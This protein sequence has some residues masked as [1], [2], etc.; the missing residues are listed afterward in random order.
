MLRRPG[1]PGRAALAA[2]GVAALGLSCTPAL[3]LWR[4]ARADRGRLASPPPGYVDDASRLNRTAVREVW[5]VPPDSAAAEAALAA[6]VRRAAREG[7]P[8]SIAGARHSQGGHTFAPG[9]LVVDLRAFR[10]MRL[11]PDG[12]VL[13]VQAGA[14]WSEVL[15]FLHARGRSVA[16]MQSNN[17]FSIGGTLSVNAHGWQ[18]RRGPFAATVRA[19]RLVTPSGEIVRCSREENAELFALVLGGYG[20]FGIVLE[21]EL[22]TVPNA[23]YRMERHVTTVPGYA[24]AYARYVERDPSAVMA[25]GRVSVA[26]RGYFQQAVLTVYRRD[27][28]PARPFPS[29]LPPPAITPLARTVFRGSVGSAYG[30]GLRWDLERAVLGAVAPRYVMRN[31]LL[32]E[33]SSGFTTRDTARTEILHEYFVPPERLSGF[34]GQ[35]ARVLPRHAPDLLNLTL[36]EVQ[37]DSVTAL[38]YATGPRQGVVLFF[39]MPRT[40]AAD[41]SMARLTREL[42]DLALAH[43][44]TYYLPYRL[45]ATPAQFRR[46]YP[47]AEAFF[48]AKRRYDPGEVFQNQFYRTYGRPAN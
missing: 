8:I 43:G 30:K 25:Y 39:E 37:P 15:P 46:A 44:G 48:A 42:V 6:L 21:A 38:R 20:L 7:V 28:G 12:R 14:R 32:N 9:G 45:H 47:H 18:A 5:P 10:R 23:W 19:L 29:R 11:S 16:V 1:R 27:D 34:L 22:E 26:P 31:A 40:A 33:P 13:H 24:E 35:M 17:D 4:T 3:H 36:R 2:L 41:S